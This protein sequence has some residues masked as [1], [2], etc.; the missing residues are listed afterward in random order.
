MNRNI[1]RE[2]DIRG[3]YPTE[4]NEEVAYQVG[5]SYGSYIQEN[6]K[7]KIC[8][9][10]RDNRL[11]SP[12]LAK[13]LIKGITDSGCDVIDFGL[14]TTP[15]YYYACLK[16][17]VIIGI[18][19]TASHNPKDDNGFKFSFDHLANARGEQVYDFRDYTL[20]G[21]FLSGHGQIT[22][23]EP[24]EYY[25]SFIKENIKMGNRPLKVVLDC[26][27]GTTSLFA[28]D[29]YSMF[30][31]LDL[32][33]ICDISDA[34]FPNH[35]P[36]PAVVENMEMLKNKVLEV[37]ADIGIAF[38]GDGDRVGFISETG[39]YLPADKVM[40]AF[41][42][43]INDKVSNKNYLYDVKCSKALEDEI[44]KL[45]G[46]PVCF[47]TGNS[48]TRAEINKRNYPFGGEY[49]GH[50]YFNDR[51]PCIDSGLYN[52]LRMLELL[53]TTDQS[54]STLFNNINTYY[55]TPEI[56][57][58]VADDIKFKVVDIVT[59]YVKSKNYKYLDID[60]I[61]VQFDDGW[62]LVRASNTGPNLTLR[63]EASSLER[64]DQL[65]QEFE[66]VVHDALKTFK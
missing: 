24:Y 63:F 64:L 66:A 22:T 17:N 51:W 35:H 15:M 56:K 32:T 50:L 44:I 41:I 27:N 23:F 65:K 25:K 4:I 59:T 18:M 3:I 48:Y 20:A 31:N 13:E 40:I 19:V 46:N 16:T 21:K 34:T 61:R 30:P 26:G 55:N 53:S 14:V 52:G 43:N 45:G 29:I 7:R 54:F 10:G 38:D 39:E 62:A 2:Y 1:F 9:V 58:A 28:K 36:D 42:R 47:R 49:S 57:L 11:S 8:G 5:R 60:G 6:L 12:T 37:K 33:M